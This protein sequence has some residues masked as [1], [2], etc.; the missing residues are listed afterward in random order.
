MELLTD[1]RVEEMRTEMRLA[2]VAAQRILEI[3]T[4][5]AGPWKAKVLK[6]KALAAGGIPASAV[7]DAYLALRAQ[8][9]LV[10]SPG[11][12]VVYRARQAPPAGGEA[13]L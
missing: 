11:Y 8:G 2:G 13:D 10:D 3:V 6:E 5:D 1:N 7:D 4:R 12:R 9:H